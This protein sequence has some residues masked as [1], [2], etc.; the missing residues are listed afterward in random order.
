MY[1]LYDSRRASD[2]A[3]QPRM[4]YDH[5]LPALRFLLLVYGVN[6]SSEVNVSCLT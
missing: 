2:V 5:D 4:N 1:M 6:V 3:Q